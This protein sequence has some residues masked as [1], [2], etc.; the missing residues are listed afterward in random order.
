MTIM[1]AKDNKEELELWDTVGKS[2]DDLETWNAVWQ[3]LM[4]LT[5]VCLNSHLSRCIPDRNENLYSK[6]C[7]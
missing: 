7:T 3:F 6:F 4:K 1:S 5:L 2:A